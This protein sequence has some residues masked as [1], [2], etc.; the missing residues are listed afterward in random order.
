[1]AEHKTEYR[2]SVNVEEGI[3]SL[4]R[5]G[6]GFSDLTDGVMS[7]LDDQVKA[8]SE[9][10]EKQL[11]GYKK[12]ISDVGKNVESLTSLELEKTGEKSDFAV[13]SLNDVTGAV[14]SSTDEQKRL[15]DAGAQQIETIYN[16]LSLAGSAAMEEVL[17]NSLHGQVSDSQDIW[18]KWSAN[19]SEIWTDSLTTYLTIQLKE[20][21]GAEL[22]TQE[23]AIQ[24]ALGASANEAAA[25]ATQMAWATAFSAITLGASLALSF[26]V[27]MFVATG[28]EAAQTTVGV[29]DAWEDVMGS[30]TR[31]VQ[32]F[33]DYIEGGAIQNAAFNLTQ[34]ADTFDRFGESIYIPDEFRDQFDALTGS[35]GQLGDAL[36]GSAE[37][38]SLASVSIE[39][40]T[41]KYEQAG[42]LINATAQGVIDFALSAGKAGQASDEWAGVSVDL[43]VALGGVGTVTGSDIKTFTDMINTLAEVDNRMSGLAATS[44]ALELAETILANSTMFTTAE[45]QTASAAMAELNDI[46]TRQDEILD[47][48][49]S[50]HTMTAGEVEA[51]QAEY[52]GL[53][54]EA[55]GVEGTLY[56]LSGAIDGADSSTGDLTTGTD[57]MTEAL[58]ALGLSAAN[59]SDTLDPLT[60]DFSSLTKDVSDSAESVTILND[61]LNALPSSKD[62]AVN[63]SY[64]YSSTGSPDSSVDPG[65]AAEPAFT[66][67][68][69]ESGGSSSSTTNINGVSI[70][71]QGSDGASSTD[72]AQAVIEE[73]NNLSR[74]GVTVIDSGGIGSGIR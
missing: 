6:T 27:D 34:I 49:A 37:N 18:K 2:L 17:V 8:G 13:K 71:V 19:V 46:S 28:D 42:P 23:L 10:N 58:A 41:A 52:A 9:A 40:L 33:V 55:T 65:I 31:N 16:D 4:E 24:A 72:I 44:E 12:Y 64:N 48:L 11:T 30:I 43:A 26:L 50:A 35:V 63:V 73:I 61:Y 20:K 70:N 36:G 29:K 45:V 56:N 67:S 74:K 62:I 15:I 3:T 14:E 5:L 69:Y 22:T 54:S 25:L 21:I 1:M 60:G 47:L 59:A 51:L 66:K 68:V 32:N 57:D 7:A 53:N 39:E 38:G